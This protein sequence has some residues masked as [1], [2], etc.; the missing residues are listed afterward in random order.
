MRGRREIGLARVVARSVPRS[1]A[2]RRGRGRRRRR[3]APRRRSRA[4]AAPSPAALRPAGCRR[5]LR[6]A[7]RRARTPH[8]TGAICSGNVSRNRP[9][10]RS[11]DVD[12]RAAELGER[13]DFEAGDARRGMIPERAHADQREGL[14]EIVAAR[15][16]GGAAPEIEHDAARPIA[17][18]LRVAG[19]QL[20]G[21]A[22]CRSPRRCGSGTARGST[23]K[24]LRPVGSTSSRPARRR[25]RRARAGRSAR[26]ARRRAAQFGVRRP[27]RRRSDPG[28]GRPRSA[29]R[30][31]A[32]PKT[33]RPSP[34]RASLRSQSQASSGR[35]SVDPCRQTAPAVV[36]Q[37]TALRAFARMRVRSRRARRGSSVTACA[38]SSN[39][40]SSSAV[41]PCSAGL[42]QRRRQMADRHGGDPPLG[43]RGLARVVDDERIDHRQR[44]R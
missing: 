7:P 23:V 44:R 20:V 40:A 25:T 28:R 2:R 42:D 12:A 26:R 32:R 9:E 22:R 36:R 43:L 17:M 27:Q 11:V 8:R 30:P 3:R 37:E 18:I 31:A 15:A 41:S 33:C 4:S 19:H 16:H 13:Q 38:Y 35:A 14:G 6:R 1:S 34:I 10:M 29:G 39:S 21:D 24:R 5:R